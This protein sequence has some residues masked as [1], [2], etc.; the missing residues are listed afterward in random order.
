MLFRSLTIQLVL[1]LMIVTALLMPSVTKVGTLSS[2]IKHARSF[3]RSVAQ[4]GS[5]SALGAE[6]R[7]FESSYSDQYAGIAQTVEQLICNHQVVG[8]IPAAS[9]INMKGKL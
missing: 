5:A 1:S 6:G 7:W 3:N 9:T 8:S 2:V 4:P